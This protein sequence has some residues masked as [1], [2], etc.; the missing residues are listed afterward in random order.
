MSAVEQGRAVARNPLYEVSDLGG[1]RRVSGRVLRPHLDRYGYPTVGLSRRSK[2]SRATVHRLVCEA[3]NGRR[4]TPLH[5]VAHGDGVRTNNVASNLRWATPKE[6]CADRNA[7]RT[8]PVGEAKP[9]IW[10]SDVQVQLIRARH[11]FGE[12]K[13]QLARCFSVSDVHIDRLVSGEM[14]REAGGFLR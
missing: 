3:F 13:A 1:V 10:L 2:I 6:N 7:H 4:P 8:A 14:R 11:A 9:N 12:S 5:Q